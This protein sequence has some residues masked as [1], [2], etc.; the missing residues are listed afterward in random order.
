MSRHGSRPGG[1]A[2]PEVSDAVIV[3]Y[4]CRSREPTL[5]PDLLD[6]WR[7]ESASKDSPKTHPS[8]HTP[9]ARMTGECF[10]R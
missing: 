6:W 10:G 3:P 9:P 4:V 7:T 8:P 2:R 5:L 1:N